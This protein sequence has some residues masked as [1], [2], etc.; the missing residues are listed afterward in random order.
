M[1]EQANTQV[2]GP[3]MGG[4]GQLCVQGRLVRLLLKLM[5]TWLSIIASQQVCHAMLTTM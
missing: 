1:V 3:G 4:G 2:T 5:A